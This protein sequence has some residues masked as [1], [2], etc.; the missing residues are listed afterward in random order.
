MYTD[1]CE[2]GP[3]IYRVSHVLLWV[4]LLLTL[5]SRHSWVLLY[6]RFENLLVWEAYFHTFKLKPV[7]VA[8]QTKYAAISL[9][10]Y[11][12]KPWPCTWYKN[13]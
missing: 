12:L 13:F 2:D 5:H 6:L 8:M 3:Y 11:T 9:Q 4:H 1:Y 10:S 7:E